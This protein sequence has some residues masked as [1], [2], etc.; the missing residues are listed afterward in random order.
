MSLTSANVYHAFRYQNGTMED[1]NDLIDDSTWELEGAGDINEGGVI[2]GRGYHNSLYRA[3]LLVPQAGPD[4]T[5][6]VITIASPTGNYLLNQA[7]TASYSCTDAESGVASFSGTVASGALI[8]TASVGTKT[9]TVTATDNAGNVSTKTVTYSV[10]FGI[11]VL[12]D[13][14]K[15]HRSGSTIPIKLQLCDANGVNVS[16]ANVLV[17][18]TSVIMASTEAP[19]PLE[20]AGNA[21]PDGNFRYDAGLGGTGGYIFN[22]STQGY[23]TGTYLL[24]FTV[25]GDPTVHSVQFQVK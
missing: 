6:P 4:T 13:Q 18:A 15:A 19:G 24:R 8:D 1:L 10:A 25:G 21:N 23:G 2:V 3:F 11:C 16:N 12:S 7:V 17:H 20:D 22:L 9:F 14:S 5:G